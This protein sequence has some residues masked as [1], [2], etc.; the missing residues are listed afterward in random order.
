MTRRILIMLGLLAVI[1]AALGFYAWH[2]KR[3]VAHDAQTAAEQ[4][5]AMTAPASGAPEPVT[6][7]VAMDSDGT[8]RKTQITVR[9]RPSA[10]N[11]RAPCC[12][13]CWHNI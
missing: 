13:P 4:Q 7:Y 6:L 3:R 12:R 11:V 5:L 9:C 2:L 8:L 1:A 10:A